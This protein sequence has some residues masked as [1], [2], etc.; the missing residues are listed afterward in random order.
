M[1]K[2]MIGWFLGVTN[3]MVTLYLDRK[4]HGKQK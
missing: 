4:R 1:L 2:Y 3:L